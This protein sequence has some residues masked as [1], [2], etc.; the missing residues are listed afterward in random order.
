MKIKMPSILLSLIPA[1][2]AAQ[3]VTLSWD[4]SPTP[5]VIGYKL[6]YRAW[7]FV[8]AMTDSGANEGSSPIDV[9]NVLTYTLTGLTDDV[10]YYFAVDA[11]D[12]QGNVSVYS[13]YVS[14]K[15]KDTIER[16]GVPAGSKNGQLK[17]E[18]VQPGLGVMRE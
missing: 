3:T 1:L 5:E 11:Y 8:F 16:S 17:K 10:I 4:A 14:T 2:C 13:N 12:D 15:D 18:A 9:G 7:P 6:Y